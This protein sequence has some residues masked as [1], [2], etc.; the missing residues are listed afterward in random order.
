MSDSDR[1]LRETIARQICIS[2]GDDPDERTGF[3]ELRPEWERQ[4]PC[5]DCVL[6]AADAAGFTIV[7][8]TQSDFVCA[9]CQG[10][11]GMPASNTSHV[12]IVDGRAFHSKECATLLTAAGA[13]T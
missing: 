6:A 8:K 5:V 10:K 7:P 12:Y 3:A 1:P 9:G 2:N 13:K 4:A 11:I